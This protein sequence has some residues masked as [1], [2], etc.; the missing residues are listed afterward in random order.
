MALQ[1]WG[2]TCGGLQYC[3]TSA[4]KAV[5][6]CLPTNSVNMASQCCS[7]LHAHV[8]P[9]SLAHALPP[10]AAQAVSC[11][12][13]MSRTLG[14]TSSRRDDVLEGRP[15]TQHAHTLADAT[16]HMHW[17]LFFAVAAQATSS[18]TAGL[19]RSCRPPRP[20][21]AGAQ[22]LR[23][24]GLR[25]PGQPLGAATVLLVCTG[26]VCLLAA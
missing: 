19:H 16:W 8:G 11:A 17:L 2:T 4:A 10:R 24:P 12:A 21:H 6:C 26:R 20:H 22:G 1:Y 3:G 23:Q 18:A 9:G 25:Q 7:R 14:C 13:A 5:L 15:H